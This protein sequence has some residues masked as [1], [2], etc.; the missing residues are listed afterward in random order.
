MCGGVQYEG[1]VPAEGDNNCDELW[2]IG[3]DE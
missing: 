2:R 1:M 3:R